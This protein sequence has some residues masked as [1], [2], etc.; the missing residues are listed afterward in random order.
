MHVQ[1][2]GNSTTSY[3]VHT[4]TSKLCVLYML[5]YNVHV[6]PH[7]YENATLGYIFSLLTMDLEVCPPS[8]DLCSLG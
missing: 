8:N 7:V 2:H 4:C 6:I 1:V 3:S 5:M